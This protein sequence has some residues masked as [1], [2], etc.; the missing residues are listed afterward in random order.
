M[1]QH[2]GTRAAQNMYVSRSLRIL[3][4]DSVFIL[5]KEKAILPGK[6]MLNVSASMTTCWYYT[7]FYAVVTSQTGETEICLDKELYSISTIDRHG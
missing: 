3:D 1:I 6:E 2:L 5:G 4:V 7:P